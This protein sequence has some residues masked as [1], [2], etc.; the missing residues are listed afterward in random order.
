MDTGRLLVR[1]EE[2]AEAELV[3][4]TVLAAD[5]LEGLEQRE[6]LKLRAAAREAL[7]DLIGA[8]E[9]RNRARSLPAPPK[10]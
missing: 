1:A 2:W 9:D 4:T 5:R 8:D 6:A 10:R 3:L 7:G